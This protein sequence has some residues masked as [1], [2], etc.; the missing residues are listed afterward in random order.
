M[1]Y[2]H[3]YFADLF[4]KKMSRVYQKQSAATARQPA[5][6]RP[7]LRPS[8]PPPPLTSS[9][10]GIRAPTRGRTM[11]T[12]PPRQERTDHNLSNEDNTPTQPER[13]THVGFV[14]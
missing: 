12:Q 14:D 7:S 3:T 11:R 9:T 4:L 1:V 10:R 5:A 13:T 8:H 2:L 6:N